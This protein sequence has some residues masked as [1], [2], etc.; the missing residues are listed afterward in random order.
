MVVH[1]RYK[2]TRNRRNCI[3]YFCSEPILQIIINFSIILRKLSMNTLMF[4]TYFI[5]ESYCFA[6]VKGSS[7]S[8]DL[9]KKIEVYDP[10]QVTL[11]ASKNFT[12]VEDLDVFSNLPSITYSF[13]E[14]RR[15]LN[16]PTK[17]LLSKVCCLCYNQLLSFIQMI[18]V[19]SFV[20]YL[21]IQIIPKKFPKF[22]I[23]YS[24]NNL[25]SNDDM[26]I[27]YLLK[28]A[29]QEKFMDFTI[30]LKMNSTPLIYYFNP[31]TN[32]VFREFLKNDDVEIFPDKLKN[33][34]GYPFKVTSFE[35]RIYP[36]E[37]FR[38]TQLAT[39]TIHKHT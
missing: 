6:V 9:E 29:W 26:Q 14:T 28:Y 32:I 24:S 4:S 36:I 31:F 10:Y 37:A 22:L 35:N 7:L 25:T 16:M 17:M 21:K 38:K 11:F 39:A 8:F 20:D 30:L 15:G 1:N 3:L 34:H 23:T 13:Y 33:A 19:K 2:E 18:S 12:E 5:F 27:L